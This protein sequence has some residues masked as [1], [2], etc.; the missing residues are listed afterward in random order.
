MQPEGRLPFDNLDVPLGRSRRRRRGRQWWHCQGGLVSHC[1]HFVLC[2]SCWSTMTKS[3]FQQRSFHFWCPESELKKWKGSRAMHV[4][5]TRTQFNSIIKNE[6][7]IIS[8]IIKRLE[9]NCS[10][11]SRC[12][13]SRRN[14]IFR[15]TQA[16][17]SK[18]HNGDGE[19]MPLKEK[20]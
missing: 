3:Q 7:L 14:L 8:F 15:R 11:I 10:C 6:H 1:L 17:G 12:Y 4:R 20:R 18:V 5:S 19:I 16:A 2:H 9:Y 13:C